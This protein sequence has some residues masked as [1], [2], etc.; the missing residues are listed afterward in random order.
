MLPDRAAVEKMMTYFDRRQV[1]PEAVLVKEGASP[2]GM[3][4]I[5]EGQVRVQLVIRDER[6]IR[7]RTMSS[8]TVIGELGT[9]LNVPATASVIAEKP[10]LL[11]H[12]SAKA[13]AEMEEKNPE[14]SSAFHRFMA[15]AIAERL[16]SAA[17]TMKVLLG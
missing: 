7:L 3:Y 12:L 9:Y 17:E 15:H 6:E 11:F 1:D 4:F 14:L 16:A 13:L 2:D 10:T 5:E 8:G